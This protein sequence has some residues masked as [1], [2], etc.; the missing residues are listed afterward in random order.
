MFCSRCGKEIR[1][2]QVFCSY[3]G[4]KVEDGTDI[5]PLINYMM[6]TEI[7][8]MVFRSLL[9]GRLFCTSAG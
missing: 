6:G 4:A 8:A 7:S 9:N 2:G 1:E 5:F 3:C